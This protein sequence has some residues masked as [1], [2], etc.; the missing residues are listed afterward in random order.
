MLSLLAIGGWKNTGGGIRR[1]VY[2]WK[3]PCNFTTLRQEDPAAM[4]LSRIP[5]YD[6]Y[7][8]SFAD[9]NITLR[10]YES[11]ELLMEFH[12][13]NPLEVNYVGIWTGFGSEGYWK[14]PS[15]CS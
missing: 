7:K 6:H 14:F 4:G 12:D 9:G 1:C 15:F 10:R 2:Q 5:A 8:I 13:P 11:Q 3:F